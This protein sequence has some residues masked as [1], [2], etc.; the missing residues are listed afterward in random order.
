MLGL[1]LP[2]RRTLSTKQYSES[3]IT[4]ERLAECPE[5]RITEKFYLNMYS[6]QSIEPI[7][8]VSFFWCDKDGTQRPR[9][10]VGFSLMWLLFQTWNRHG[11]KPGSHEAEAFTKLEA[12]AEALTL[13]N[14][15]AEALVTKPKPKPKP[16]YL[17]YTHMQR[18]APWEDAFLLGMGVINWDCRP[19]NFISNILLHASGAGSPKNRPGSGPRRDTDQWPFSSTIGGLGLTLMG[20]LQNLI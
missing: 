12:E 16:G 9:P 4:K 3:G 19:M 2:C 15:E 10:L 20:S 17:Y 6:V 8:F 13:I 1:I 18:N 7:T 14:L 11:P 5:V